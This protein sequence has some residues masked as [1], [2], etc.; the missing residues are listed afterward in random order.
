M[1]L[2]TVDSCSVHNAKFCHSVVLVICCSENVLVS[3]VHGICLFSFL[4]FVCC[5]GNF[6]CS[7]YGLSASFKQLIKDK[8]NK[9]YRVV[10]KV[11]HPV[12]IAVPTK[13]NQLCIKDMQLF[14]SMLQTNNYVVKNSVVGVSM[15]N[16][17]CLRHCC[18][19]SCPLYTVRARL[20]FL[21]VNI[22][23]LT[24]EMPFSNKSI[25]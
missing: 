15:L 2:P 7:C 10:Q 17:R 12:L 1:G 14:N 21:M 8:I 24:V 19:N 3:Y 5:S 13:E 20:D 16:I 23:Y 6:V 22:E 9:Q 25:I 11:T 18:F 4:C